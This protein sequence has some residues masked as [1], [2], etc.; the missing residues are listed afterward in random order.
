M[1]LDIYIICSVSVTAYFCSFYYFYLYICIVQLC[2][3]TVCYFFFLSGQQTGW[4][5]MI[6]LLLY[7]SVG[8]AL[9]DELRPKLPDVLLIA[10]NFGIIYLQNPVKNEVSVSVQ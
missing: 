9:E 4:Y 6:C 5:S 8:S 2:I 7:K 1:A 3:V 10:T